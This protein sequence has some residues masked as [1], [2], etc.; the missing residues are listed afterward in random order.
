MIYIYGL[1]TITAERERGR[2]GLIRIKADYMYGHC[3]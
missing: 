1:E 2:D 3:G